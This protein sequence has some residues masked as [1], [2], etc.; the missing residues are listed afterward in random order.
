MNKV[1]MVLLL[2]FRSVVVTNE[3]VILVWGGDWY[4]RWLGDLGMGVYFGVVLV[5]LI[6]IVWYLGL[7]CCTVIFGDLDGVYFGVSGGI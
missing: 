1:I 2:E 3:G 5:G 4:G 6:N 7:L